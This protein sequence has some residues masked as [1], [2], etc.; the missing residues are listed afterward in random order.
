MRGTGSLCDVHKYTSDYTVLRAEAMLKGPAEWGEGAQ[1]RLSGLYYFRTKAPSFPLP[2]GISL[3]SVLP[4]TD[5]IDEDEDDE[6]VHAAVTRGCPVPALRRMLRRVAFF[7]LDI[8]TSRLD[9][10]YCTPYPT[11]ILSLHIEVCCTCRYPT[12]CSAH[13]LQC[14]AFPKPVRSG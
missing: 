14:R 12:E 9:L 13:R 4:D 2:Y 6:K 1:R 8:S 7:S 5:V 11:P 3:R 10:L